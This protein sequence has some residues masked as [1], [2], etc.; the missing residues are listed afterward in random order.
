V[1]FIYVGRCAI[2]YL[3]ICISLFLSPILSPEEAVYWVFE[4][5][6]GEDGE[7]TML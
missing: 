4:L 1:L 7:A 2:H 6:V 5:W 3:V